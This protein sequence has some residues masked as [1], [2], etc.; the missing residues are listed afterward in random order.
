LPSGLAEIR[1][2]VDERPLV[3]HGWFDLGVLGL[4]SAV[5][6]EI[7]TGVS[8]P[9]GGGEFFSVDWRFWAHRPLYQAAVAAPAPWRGV[10]RLAVSR[11]RQPFTSEFSPTVHD[12]LTLDVADWASG[13][14]RWQFGAGVDRWN[15]GRSFA[16]AGGGLRLLTFGDRVD[17]RAQFRTWFGGG[18][19]FRR[20][21][22]RVLAR[23]STRRKGVVT[24]LD[25]GVGLTSSAAPADLWFAGDIGRARPFL[26]RAHPLLTEGERFKTERLA[27]TF[28]HATTEIQRWWSPGP[29]EAGVAAFVDSGQTA[30]RLVGGPV[31]D[32]DL[33][34]GLRA[35]YPGHSGIIRLDVARGARDGHTALS[36]TYSSMIE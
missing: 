16:T 34:F 2:T 6:R 36:V 8:S 5:T 22:I 13:N 9:M 31:T 21:E 3:P 19:A 35:A 17:A 32:V 14:V 12:S 15:G 25:G 10:W 33:G 4:A 11:E 20:G 7:G 27:R 28:L 26:L 30:R 18:T 23:S 29:F 1:G 24:F